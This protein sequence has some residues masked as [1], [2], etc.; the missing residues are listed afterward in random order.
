[1][2]LKIALKGCCL[3]KYGINLAFGFSF[4]SLNLWLVHTEQ[5]NAHVRGGPILAETDGPGD[6]LSRGTIYFV[7]SHSG[8]ENSM[9]LSTS[10]SLRLEKS[11]L[12]STAC[13]R[14]EKSMEVYYDTL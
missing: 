14:E 11:P 12:V 2:T 6:H 8:Q 7:T 13:Y 1:M 3:N 10:G 5:V 4:D 9:M